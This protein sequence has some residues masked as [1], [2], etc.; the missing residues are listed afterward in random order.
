MPGAAHTLDGRH[1]MLGITI[2]KELPSHRVARRFL[3][4]RT[5]DHAPVMLYR[6]GA[7]AG[8]AERASFVD[9]TFELRHLRAENICSIKDAAVAVDGGCWLVGSYAGHAAGV[10]TL[11]DAVNAREGGRLSR[12]E[13]LTV[14]DQVLSAAAAAH[15]V[16][17]V[18][19]VVTLDDLLLTPRGRVVVEL[20][21]LEAS[22]RRTGSD[23][24][25]LRV[26]VA[27]EVRS[28][29]MLAF[30]LLTG[31]A[32]PEEE[33][34]SSR[35][36]RRVL[37][38]VVPCKHWR[39]WLTLA[40]LGG[41]AA[42]E[43]RG[44]ASSVTPRGSERAAGF[45]S[46]EQALQALRAMVSGTTGVGLAAGLSGMAIKRRD[47]GWQARLL[48]RRMVRSTLRSTSRLRRAWAARPGR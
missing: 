28:I 47:W 8:L 36:A 6:M 1:G 2:V 40:L 17:I 19:G 16:G 10:T 44:V 43:Q 27:Q 7:W 18:H 42:A 46:A 30:Q 39:A 29:A 32:W 14:I 9:R 21:G 25:S 34:V 45:A 5:D 22:L 24:R 26:S 41:D 48:R 33:S 37:A 4:R 13:A 15:R 11:R 38:R 23:R 35:A 31:N 3:A 12:H 20:Y